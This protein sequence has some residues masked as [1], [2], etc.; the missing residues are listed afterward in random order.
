MIDFFKHKILFIAVL[1]L[2][3]MASKTP[4]LNLKPATNNQ[5]K[6]NND[7]TSPNRSPTSNS[8]GNQLLKPLQKPLQ[9]IS[10]SAT[11]ELLLKIMLFK[12]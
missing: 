10:G 11:G 12:L 8:I 5:S 9:L 2:V 6:V 3:Q 1:H 7:A 4:N